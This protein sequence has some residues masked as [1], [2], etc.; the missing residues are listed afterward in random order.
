MKSRSE[1]LTET[2]LCKTEIKRLFSISKS[3][4][5]QAFDVAHQTDLD[6][7]G[8]QRMFYYGKKVRTTTVA[9]VLGVNLN[10]LA[11]QIKKQSDLPKS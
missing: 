11:N 1:L 4:A 3:V 6:E 8:R 5:S 9:K 7:L 2:Y 10:Q